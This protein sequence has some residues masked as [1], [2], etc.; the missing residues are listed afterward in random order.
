V[1]A[2]FGDGGRR[3]LDEVHALDGAKQG[4]GWLG[5]KVAQESG[6]GVVSGLQRR[7][8]RDA[9]V[10]AGDGGPLA[11]GLAGDE[12]YPRDV[13]LEE[14]EEGPGLAQGVARV[15]GHGEGLAGELDAAL[16][17]VVRANHDAPAAAPVVGLLLERVG[18]LLPHALADG[19]R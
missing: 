4:P 10:E 6:H 18:Q 12:P 17:V 2:A 14:A 3:P 5:S 15:V 16:A 9:D 19:L 8:S 1:A 11:D 7:G 13:D